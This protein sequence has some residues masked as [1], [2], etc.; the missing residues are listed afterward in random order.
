MAAEA[1]IKAVI[2]AEDRASDVIGKFGHGIGK[3]AHLAAVGIGIASTAVVGFGA[4]SVKAFS[5]SQDVIAQ[6]NAVIKSTGG[7]AG[8]TAEKVGELASSLQRVTKFSDEAI[9]E[10]E[11]LLLTFTNIGQDIFPQA[12]EIM[13][14]MS[15][16]LG[17]DLKSSAIQLGKALQDPVL[18]VTALRRVGVNF[19][20]A[21]T[22]VIKNLV[23][24][25]QAA[26][27]QRLIMEELTKEFGGSAKA[28]G[29]T[30]SGQLAILK[31]TFGDTMEEI[32]GKIITVLMPAFQ[33]IAD[34]VMAHKEDIVT[35]F[36]SLVN[37]VK[38]LATG[39]FEGG[40]F[41]WTE[42]SPWINALLSFRDAVIQIG[43][44][45]QRVFGWVQENGPKILENLRIA[46][47][48]IK[49]HIDALWKTIQDDLIPPLKRLWEEV[50]KPLL[51]ILGVALIAALVLVIE[52]IR[53]AASI[54]GSMID[55]F[56]MAKNT[57]VD[58]I[59]AIVGVFLNIGNQIR[60]GFDVGV[61][62]GGK[63]IEFQNSLFDF[64]RKLVDGIV[65]FFTGL[66]DRIAEKITGVGGAI[67]DKLG[68]I[69]I[70]G[71]G[72]LR[73]TIPGFASGV[74][75]FSGGPAI[76]GERGPELLNLPRGSDVIPLNRLG[77][78]TI[79]LN[80]NIGMFAGTP[81][82]RRRIAQTM[83]DDLRDIATTQGMTLDKLVMS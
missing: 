53:I 56:I 4:A 77:G 35:F 17:Q 31:N 48:V 63:L 9:Q 2:S 20:E 29:E 32:G 80:V 65:G 57:V 55:A 37:I 60:D 39:D 33:K 5:E 62:L 58:I 28:A 36:E 73:D 76:V 69:D 22:E 79:N 49:P 26:E 78:S 68:S 41:G 21:Q 47:E 44:V 3:A 8:V 61:K 82:E 81:T 54:A 74:T 6:T 24:T 34:F 14:D 7:V 27:A 64:F 43:D 50:I 23:E 16:A 1:H 51:P 52:T 15:Q 71:V 66:P 42:D 72:S 30:L 70:P 67:R 83:L 10:G 11:N 40:I 59:A 12:T 19:N 38:L 25:G 13:L 75:N 18:G 45:V 46:F